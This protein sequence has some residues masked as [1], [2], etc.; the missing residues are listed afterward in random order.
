VSADADPTRVAEYAA[1]ND[2]PWTQGFLGE[3]W[4]HGDTRADYGLASLPYIV[5]IGPDGK[6]IASDLCCDA[7]KPAVANALKN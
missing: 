6:I 7:I 3:H 4:E 5:L 1:K 2:L